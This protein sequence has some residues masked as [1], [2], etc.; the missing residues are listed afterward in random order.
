MILQNKND[1]VYKQLDD[2]TTL[3][4][5]MEIPTFI[6]FCF[7]YAYKQCFYKDVEYKRHRLYDLYM[8]ETN[9]Y[10][11]LSGLIYANFKETLLKNKNVKKE[12]S[13]E[14]FYNELEDEEE[15]NLEF[16]FPN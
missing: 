4:Q 15:Q 13:I 12:M 16:L 8:T 1:V 14:E 6:D 7:V 2:K 3:E 9:T 5:L 10:T 11:S